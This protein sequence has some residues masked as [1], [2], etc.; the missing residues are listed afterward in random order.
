MKI[1]IIHYRYYE[2]SGPERYLFNVSKLLKENGHKVIPFS[3]DFKQNKKSKYSKH[4]PQ[5][6]VDQFH[7]S[8][9]SNISAKNKLK[10]IKN[11]F[12]NKDVFD[13]LDELIKKENPD[14]AYVLQYGNKLLTSICDVCKKNKLPVVLRLSD[15]NLIDT[16]NSICYVDDMFS[17]KNPYIGLNFGSKFKGNKE[18][19]D[20]YYQEILAILKNN[21]KFSDCKWIKRIYEVYEGK[22]FDLLPNICIELPSDYGVEYNLFSE[23]LTESVTH[24]KI[25]GGQLSSGTLGVFPYKKED[26]I[27]DDILDFKKFAKHLEN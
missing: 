10:I 24:Y 5:P 26:M 22:H 1:I 6:V 20:Q 4:F 27:I 9:Q 3:L 11:S 15:I 16:L 17:G 13:K 7:V 12:Y 2:A 25:S 14:I 23:I 21:P 18:L 19:E 8:Q